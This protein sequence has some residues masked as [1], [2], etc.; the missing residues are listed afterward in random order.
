VAVA[1]ADIPEPTSYAE[2][3]D[4]VFEASG[5]PASAARA[6]DLIRPGGRVC[7]VGYQVGAEHPIET[8]KFPLSYAS[9][10]GVMGPGGKFQQAVDLLA[11]GTIAAG[12]I[13]TDTVA[14]DDFAP[15]IDRALTR[16]GGTVR[17][18]FDLR[19]E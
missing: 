3:F 12:P 16:T 7:L 6:L 4:V 15:A 5:D 18:L 17:V 10:L 8:A 9:V 19:A 1:P 13:L 2:K 11:A 14:L